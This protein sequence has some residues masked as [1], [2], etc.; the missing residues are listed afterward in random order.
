MKLTSLFKKITYQSHYTVIV[1]DL[2]SSS[3]ILEKLQ[4][5]GNIKK[6]R[7]MWGK[8][9]NHLIRNPYFS[10]RCVPYKFVGDGFIILYRSYYASSLIEFMHRLDTM[11]CK[12]LDAILNEFNITPKRHGFCYGIDEGNLVSMKLLAKTE[13]MGEAINAAT[14]LQSQLKAPEDASS[15]MF[16]E[17][18]YAKITIPQDMKQQE[19][20]CVLRNLYD[21]REILCHQLWI[22]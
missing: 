7:K 14:R 11:A 3:V 10:Q 2:C 17:A 1:M 21:D 8:I 15:I 16:S 18:V 6:W 4:M 9:F 19:R 12:H 5:H 20:K 13:Y 22:E